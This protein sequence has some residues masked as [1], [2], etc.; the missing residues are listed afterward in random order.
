MTI[1]TG[2]TGPF[3]PDM[4][5]WENMDWARFGD[6]E[7]DHSLNSLQAELLLD[8]VA[9]LAEAAGEDELMNKAI[10]LLVYILNTHWL[11][12]HRWQLTLGSEEAAQ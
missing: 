1:S 7:V 9:G 6:G 4:E 10:E 11:H 3:S 2:L 8:A 5:N 12:G